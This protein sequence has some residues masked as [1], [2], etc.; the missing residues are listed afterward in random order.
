MATPIRIPRVGQTAADSTLVEWTRSQGDTV[1]AGDVIAVI[2]NDK[3]EVEIESPVAGVLGDLRVNEG[4]TCAQGVLLVYVLAAGEAE[5]KAAPISPRARKLADERGVSLDGIAGS[6]PGGLIT[7][8]DVP[9]VPAATSVAPP[10]PASSTDR[11]IRARRTLAA[12]RRSGAR[13]LTESWTSAPHFVQMFDVDM[14]ALQARRTPTVGYNELVVA[15][16]ATALA[17]YPALN[18]AY[19]DGAIVEWADVNVGLAVEGPDGLVV[20]VAKNADQLSL[21]ELAAQLRNLGGRARTGA[22]RGDD[23][24]HGS[25]TVSNLG[26]WGVKAGTAVLNLSE[27]VLL[28]VGAIED[29]AVVRNGQVAV[30]SMATLSF[31]FDHRVVDGAPAADFARAVIAKLEAPGPLRP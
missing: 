30:R 23:L 9:A 2:E 10:T 14:S 21:D 16:L 19:D 1:A 5:P 31:V 4:D 20:P 12:V 24:K 6:G 17:E 28:F 18:A 25:A 8:R 7:E 3:T 22:L 13:R 29:R 27:A 11:P 26:A 15:A